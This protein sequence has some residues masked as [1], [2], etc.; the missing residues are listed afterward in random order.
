MLVGMVLAAVTMLGSYSRSNSVAPL[1]APLAVL[2]VP[3]FDLAFVVICRLRLGLRIYHGSPDHFAVRLRRHGQS[4][5]TIATG[6]MVATFGACSAAWLA[7]TRS[8][9]AAAAVGGLGAVL[10]LWCGVR[11]WRLDPRREKSKSPLAASPETSA[12]EPAR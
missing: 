3:L 6:A 5:R 9:I 11:L 10:C 1:V 2:V 7:V 12:Q 4:A 8:G